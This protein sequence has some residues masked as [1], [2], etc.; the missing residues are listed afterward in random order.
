MTERI[1]N[2]A[3]FQHVIFTVDKTPKYGLIKAVTR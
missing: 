3:N 1:V 2:R